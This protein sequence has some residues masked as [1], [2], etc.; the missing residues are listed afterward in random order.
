VT[1]RVAFAGSEAAIGLIMLAAYA[2][3]GGLALFAL[4][5]LLII[6]QIDVDAESLA[7]SAVLGVVL[8]L[9]CRAIV[10]DFRRVRV[11][12]RADDGTWTLVGPF[13]VRRGA[14]APDAPR[15][16][17]EHQQQTW[18]LVGVARRYRRSWLEITSGGRRWQTCMNPVGARR[19]AFATVR[20]WPEARTAAPLAN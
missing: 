19:N 16:L 5:A 6:R 12:E 2:L 18:I 20:T 15:E 13:G 4:L 7:G 17:L 11:I 9:W 1:E 8:A 3:A 14:I 10:R